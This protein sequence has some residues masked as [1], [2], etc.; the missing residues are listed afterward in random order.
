M[1]VPPSTTTDFTNITDLFA[2]VLRSSVK[3]SDLS[4]SWKQGSRPWM[5]ENMADKLGI[6]ILQGSSFY[7]INNAANQKIHTLFLDDWTVYQYAKGNT[8]YNRYGG[9]EAI[10]FDPETIAG[11]KF[12]IHYMVMN[13]PNTFPSSGK[14]SF[15]LFS[16][17]NYK[18][19][20]DGP[21]KRFNKGVKGM[22][23]ITNK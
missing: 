3:D 14:M 13:S 21:I 7:A 16:G 20:Y 1:Y 15:N 22:W 6:K 9:N 17:G 10:T 8:S 18:Y 23:I 11:R 2:G 12:G 4:S 19:Q 5:V